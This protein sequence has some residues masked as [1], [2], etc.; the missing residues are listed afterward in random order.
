MKTFTRL[1][2]LG[3]LSMAG[4]TLGHNHGAGIAPPDRAL[5]RCDAQCPEHKYQCTREGGHLQ[6]LHSCP[7]FHSF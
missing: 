3:I 1:S 5:G 6:M 7:K 2:L 4:I